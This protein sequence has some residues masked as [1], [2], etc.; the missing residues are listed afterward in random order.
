[1]NAEDKYISREAVLKAFKLKVKNP[2]KD[3]QRGMQD[4]I[5]CL[6]PEVIADIPA[7]DV[8]LVKHACWL[9]V[10]EKFSEDWTCSNC[11]R[12]KGK[13]S[14]SNFCSYCGARMDGKKATLTE[15]CSNYID[16][17]GNCFIDDTPCD[18][19]GNI[20]KCKGR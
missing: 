17:D 1:M 11:M 8:Q 13:G 19:A 12:A 4:A 2:K 7:A 14:G 6:V 18:C 5:D 3:Y 9:F 15:R 20:E 16:C 10:G